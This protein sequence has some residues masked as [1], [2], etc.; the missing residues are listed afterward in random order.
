MLIVAASILALF[1]AP[2]ND[3]E[4]DVFQQDSAAMPYSGEGK[5]KPVSR[6]A[7]ENLKNMN[8]GTQEQAILNRK[9]RP[10]IMGD[11]PMAMQA[12]T[13]PLNDTEAAMFESYNPQ[14]FGTAP[15]GKKSPEKTET[16]L[17]QKSYVI[18]IPSTATAGPS[19]FLERQVSTL[20]DTS[21]LMQQLIMT[22]GDGHS[23]KDKDKD[24][25]EDEEDFD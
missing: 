13:N 10:R 20:S 1:A 21:S 4:E 15:S 22:D 24:E 6:I 25:D 9:S 19:I 18:A 23:D 8:T 14:V 11:A 3:L 2:H 16:V 7:K 5:E 17:K 12:P